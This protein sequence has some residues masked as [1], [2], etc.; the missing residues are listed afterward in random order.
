MNQIKENINILMISETKIDD[1]FPEIQFCFPGFSKPFR[2]DRTCNG[3]GILLFIREDIPSKLIKT[4][5]LLENFEGFFV[6]INLRRKKWLLCCSYNSHKNK[7]SSHLDII[8]KSLD[9]FSTTY[10]NLI[11]LGDFNVEP[12]EK[13]MADFLNVYNLKNLVHQKHAS[14]ILTIPLALI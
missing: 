11:L 6:E 3:G 9:D 4:K 8:S 2:L 13:H 10:D 1:T 14:K 7:I 5:F 12:E